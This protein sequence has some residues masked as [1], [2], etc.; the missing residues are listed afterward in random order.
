M[1]KTKGKFGHSLDEEYFHCHK[2]GHWF[3]NGKK[4]LEEQK[5][6]KESETST[7]GINIIEINITVSSSDS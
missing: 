5:K 1:P 4:Y 2:K 7:S 6:K 3:M